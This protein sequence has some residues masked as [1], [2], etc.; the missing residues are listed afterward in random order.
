MR[1]FLVDD[2]A[3]F[4]EGLQRLLEK[5]TD[6]E[7][8]A[9]ASSGPEAL[10]RIPETTPD[11]ILLDLKMPGM[12][13]LATLEALTAAGVEAWIIMLTVSDDEQ[14]LVATLRAGAAGYLLKDTEPDELNR[15]LDRVLDGETVISPR[16]TNSLVAAVRSG[17][18]KEVAHDPLANL[19]PRERE[20]LRHIAMGRSNKLIARDLTIS[21]DT[22]KLHV[23][24]LL[25]KLEVT[26]RVSAAIVATRCGLVNG[27][28]D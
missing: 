4:R 28:P 11:T 8:V 10:R 18:G 27:E 25:R 23:K 19:T 22:V 14:D 7:V 17:D 21:L 3:L 2:H 5:R 26:S 20:I 1:V 9:T 12:D 6:L 13:G 15:S 24:N 16:L